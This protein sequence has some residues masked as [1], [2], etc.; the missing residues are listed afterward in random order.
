MGRYCAAVSQ[1]QM[2]LEKTVFGQAFV[3]EG[4]VQIVSSV[5]QTAK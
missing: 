4:G 5:G 3:S 2:Q 1:S